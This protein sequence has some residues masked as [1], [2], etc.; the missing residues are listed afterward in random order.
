MHIL[1]LICNE[2]LTLLF[3]QLIYVGQ[4]K[5]LNIIFINNQ[6]F[7]ESCLKLFLLFAS[8]CILLYS[9]II[10]LST[11]QIRNKYPKVTT[12]MCVCMYV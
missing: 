3:S 8:C 1:V 4:Y 12:C 5:Q 10:R 6:V 7:S 2:D 9:I 11:Q